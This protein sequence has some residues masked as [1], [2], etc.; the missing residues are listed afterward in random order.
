MFMAIALG[1]TAAVS[2]YGAYSSSKS[3][4]A[5]NE[6]QA[7]WNRYNALMQNNVSS[8]NLNAQAQLGIFNANMIAQQGRVKSEVSRKVAAY[9]A[10]LLESSMVY[11]D[12]LLARE[13]ALL[14]EKTDLDIFML[15]KQR[16]R[17]RGAMIA[18]MA[19]SGTDINE[20]T[21]ADIIVSQ[22]TQEALDAFIIRHGAD[23]QA[24][25]IE[26]SRNKNIYE[27]EMAIQRTLW[28][29]E[30]QAFTDNYNA[31]MQ[32]AS[33]GA[34]TTVSFLSG[35]QSAEYQL[36]AGMYGAEISYANNDARISNQLTSSLMNTAT[37]TIMS[38]VSA[39][40]GGSL[41]SGGGEGVGVDEGLA[42]GA[43][44]GW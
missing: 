38:G 19:A 29:G 4:S 24:Q 27:G 40:N 13:E 43:T 3:A 33:I 42:V 34:E 18:D 30:M 23:I 6:N 25:K 14:W 41:L 1:V 37:K 15:E 39:Y 26:D 7:A 36:Q 9:N 11:N 16:A 5:Q 20:G 17:E 2:A 8:Q 12:S 22:K 32:A 31:S 10:D 28:D 44:E 35:M 21:N